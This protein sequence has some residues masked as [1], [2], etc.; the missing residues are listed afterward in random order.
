MHNNVFSGNSTNLLLTLIFCLG[1]WPKNIEKK[2]DSLDI[3]DD[4][5]TQVSLISDLFTISIYMH[6]T[7]SWKRCMTF[8]ERKGKYNSP[9]G[10]NNFVSPSKDNSKIRLELI[11]HRKKKGKNLTFK[12]CLTP[13]DYMNIGISKITKQPYSLICGIQHVH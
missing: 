5:W 13:P 11:L 4:M 10:Y 8:T 2:G 12:C 1:K 6:F 3:R 9:E 7:F